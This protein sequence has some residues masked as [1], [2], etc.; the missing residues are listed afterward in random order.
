MCFRICII[1]IGIFYCKLKCKV[2]CACEGV[3]ICNLFTRIIRVKAMNI[4]TN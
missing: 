1:M 2:M 4:F 3:F